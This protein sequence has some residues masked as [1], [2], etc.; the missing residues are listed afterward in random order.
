MVWDPVAFPQAA[1]QNQPSFLMALRD[2]RQHLGESPPF[3]FYSIGA[4]V[5][6]LTIHK[7]PMAVVVRYAKRIVG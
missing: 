3:V 6:E 4:L 7:T 1:M 2:D 5:V